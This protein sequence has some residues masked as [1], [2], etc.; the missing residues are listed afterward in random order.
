VKEQVDE[1]LRGESRRRAA[2]VADGPAAWLFQPHRNRRT[3]VHD[4]PL[5]HRRV[6]KLVARRADYAGPGR[7]TPHD[8]RRTVI[9]KM[10]K[11]H[12]VQEALMASKHRDVRTLMGLRPGSR[13]PGAHPVNIFWYD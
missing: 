8:L 10:L 5:S 6:Q 12:P 4:K 11:T 3:L 13:E 1:Y 2:L 9:T 7:V